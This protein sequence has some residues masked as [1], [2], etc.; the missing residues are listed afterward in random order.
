MDSRRNTAVKRIWPAIEK[1]VP[2]TEANT[3]ALQDAPGAPSDI[4]VELL[5]LSDER[6]HIG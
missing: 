4:V 1:L 5:A 2:A 6:C 3:V